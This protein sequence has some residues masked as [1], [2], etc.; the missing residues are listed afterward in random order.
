MV[1]V[2]QEAAPVVLVTGCSQGGIGHALC[3]EYAKLGAQVYATARH[4][5]AMQS[6]REVH[7]CK[8]LE[9]DVENHEQV[10]LVVDRVVDEAG[11]IDV[12]S[13]LV[14][15]APSARPWLSTVMPLCVWTSTLTLQPSDCQFAPK[16][17]E[18]DGA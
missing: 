7:G 6:L 4:L 17:T 3:V 11:R 16:V 5:S 9:L 18:A 12:V 14:L 2:S 1:A 15:A 13:V 8:L 10:R